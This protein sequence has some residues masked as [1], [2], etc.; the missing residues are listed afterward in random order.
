M[1]TSEEVQVERRK[2]EGSRSKR[3]RRRIRKEKAR[4]TI[5]MWREKKRV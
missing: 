5:S 2:D 4:G 1:R 3:R